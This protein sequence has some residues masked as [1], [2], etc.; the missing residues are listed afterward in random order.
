LV[1]CFLRASFAPFPRK[2]KQGG[3]F[4][5]QSG[6]R[7]G[8]GIRVKTIA[9]LGNSDVGWPLPLPLQTLEIIESK[10]WEAFGACRNSKF[11]VIAAR[12]TEGDLF[13]AV[14]RDS[15]ALVLERLGNINSA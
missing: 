12:T 5:N 6:A 14:P 15:L 4:L 1:S 8:P 2:W 7:W 13:L 11:Q 3:L 10:P 9:R